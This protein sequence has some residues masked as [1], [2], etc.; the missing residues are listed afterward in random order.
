VPTFILLSDGKE[1]GRIV[2]HSEG[3]IEFDLVYLL[4]KK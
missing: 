1:I 2:E 3:G 4:Q